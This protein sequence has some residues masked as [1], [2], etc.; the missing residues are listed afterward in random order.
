MNNPHVRAELSA[1]MTRVAL[2][3]PIGR[4]E[5]PELPSDAYLALSN[6]ARV[7]LYDVSAKAISFTQGA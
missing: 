1:C 7:E 6:E 4:A 3:A 2:P 5:N